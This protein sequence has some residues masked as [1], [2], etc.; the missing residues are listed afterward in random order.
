MQVLLNIRVYK[1]KI[2]SNIKFLKLKNL[3]S[4]NSILINITA[5]ILL[6]LSAFSV[7]AQN[8]LN[9]ESV[10]LY[11]HG[12]NSGN[13]VGPVASE[14]TD[15]VTTG[16]IMKYYVIPDATVNPGYT[17]ILSGTL[18]STFN[19]TATNVTGSAAGVINGVTGYLTYLNYKQVA[20]SGTGTIDINAQEVSDSG[21]ASSTIITVPVA[22]IAAPTVQF[23]KTDSGICRTEADGSINY[24]L[25]N[26][27]VSW[28]SSVSGSRQLKVN[29][30]IACTNPGFGGTQNHNNIS[31][32]ETGAGTGTF[33][34]PISLNYYGSYTITL[35]NISDRIS[36]KSDV[37]G[38]IGGADEFT[39]ALN[40]TPVTR[41]VLHVPN[42]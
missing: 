32:N 4:I 31:I 3:F 9:V 18:N 37:S 5:I 24:N 1:E 42:Q 30:S 15:S 17:G 34:L 38:I 7:Y 35:T 16:S 13:P 26:I 23:S 10:D 33:N 22:I 41:P 39:F 11:K 40:K 29:I 14:A 6:N 20:W 19:W 21:C 12:T 36:S 28:S 8:P 25:T 27:P 2:N